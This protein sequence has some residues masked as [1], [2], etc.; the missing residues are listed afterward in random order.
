MFDQALILEN[1]E[2][3]RQPNGAFIAAPTHDY[4]ALWIR[5]HLFMTFCYYYLGRAHDEKL[6]Q[7][8]QV[9]FNVFHTQRH[10][11]ERIMHPRDSQGKLIIPELIHAKY[12]PVTLHEVTRDW[13]HHQLDATGLFLYIVADLDQKNISVLR[14]KGDREILQLLVF[15]LHNVQYWR[16]PDN[17]MWEECLIRRSSSIGAVVGG[18]SYIQRRGLATVPIELITKGRNELHRI[19]EWESRDR[20]AVAHHDHTCDAAQLFLI[21][22]FNIID[23]DTADLILSRIINGYHHNGAYRTLIQPFGIHR[24]WG[25]DYRRSKNDISAQWQWEFL[26]AIIYAQRHDYDAARMWFQRAAG[27]ITEQGYI[28]EAFTDEGPND[29]TPL[30]W[31]HALALIAFSK[32]PRELQEKILAQ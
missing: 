17:G 32:F 2:H 16:E 30:G 1:M 5:D 3:L 9:I 31:N 20:C 18:L 21:W 14:D 12:D 23:R 28:T 22:P 15:Y 7:G 27:R 24:Y 13:G 26:L 6:I 10:K 8:L 25:D 29:H 4:S 19:L 11:L